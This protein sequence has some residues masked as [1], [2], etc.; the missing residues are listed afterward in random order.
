M[1]LNVKNLSTLELVEALDKYPQNEYPK[2]HSEI[3]LEMTARRNTL[4]QE[5][6]EEEVQT[7]HLGSSFITN[8]EKKKK[9]MTLGFGLLIIL[10][11]L[12][13][14]VTE[15]SIGFSV[16]FGCFLISSYL[17]NVTKIS[18][19]LKQ[20]T[21]IKRLHNCNDQKQLTKILQGPFYLKACEISIAIGLGAA[22]LFLV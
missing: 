20:D 2:L 12:Q 4:Q 21:V 11:I 3:C 7:K 15:R 19:L 22:Y 10:L 9:L 16:L 13:L 1:E 5:V 8:W 18:Y 17:F 14:L 6:L